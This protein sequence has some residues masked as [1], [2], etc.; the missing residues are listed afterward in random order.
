M[1]WQTQWGE[2]SGWFLASA[3][4]QRLGNAKLIYLANCNE[5]SGYCCVSPSPSKESFK[6]YVL[7]TYLLNEY[8][9]FSKTKTINVNI[10]IF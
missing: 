9:L 4:T 8:V 10:I 7:N 1:P 5:S 6:P 3:V 2:N